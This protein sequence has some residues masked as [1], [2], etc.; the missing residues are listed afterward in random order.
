M[1]TSTSVSRIET[2]RAEILAHPI[3]VQGEGGN[4]TTFAAAC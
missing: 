2:I 1:N 3:A 4:A